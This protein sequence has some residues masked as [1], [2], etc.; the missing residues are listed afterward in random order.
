M[1]QIHHYSILIKKNFCKIIN[2]KKIKICL[3]KFCVYFE[4]FKKTLKNWI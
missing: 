3:T 2:F 1:L 4:L